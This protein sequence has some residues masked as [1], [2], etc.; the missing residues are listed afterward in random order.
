MG[1]WAGEKGS[2]QV[3]FILLLR[4]YQIKPE[5][6]HYNAVSITTTCVPAFMA[7]SGC[8]SKGTGSCELFS[9]AR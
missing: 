2:G 5:Q 3:P 7:A 6:E 4:A 9:E 1:A 8:G